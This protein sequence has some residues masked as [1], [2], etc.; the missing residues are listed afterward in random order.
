MKNK[1][2]SLWK[3]DRIEKDVFRLVTSVEQSNNF[4][5]QGGI[6]PQTYGFLATKFIRH[7]P[8]YIYCYRINNVDSVMF[9]KRIRG[10]ISLELGKEIGKDVFSSCHERGTN[11]QSMNLHQTIH[12]NSVIRA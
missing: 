3:Y 6:A 11:S 12:V 4:K 9:V 7:V 10:M 1:G 2:I 5:S 8:A